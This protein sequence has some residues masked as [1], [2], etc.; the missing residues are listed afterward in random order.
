MQ[1]QILVDMCF[2][3]ILFLIDLVIIL[4]YFAGPTWHYSESES[5]SAADMNRT[6]QV[7]HYCFIY[8]SVVRIDSKL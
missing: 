2:K 3:P 4:F 5:S 1:F 7:Y 6:R 8:K